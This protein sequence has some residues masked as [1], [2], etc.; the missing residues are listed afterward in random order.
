[1]ITEQRIVPI[2]LERKYDGVGQNGPYTIGTWIV[3]TVVDSKQFVVT[4][5]GFLHD[6]MLSHQDKEIDVTIEVVM[7]EYQ[8]KYYNDVK[9]TKVPQEDTNTQDTSSAIVS[10]VNNFNP[11]ASDLPF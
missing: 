9:V 7:K 4:A 10:T 2:R 3:K 11:Q 6:Y 1:M 5:F 8:G